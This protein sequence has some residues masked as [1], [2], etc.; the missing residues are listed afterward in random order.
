MQGVRK[1]A[2]LRSMAVLIV[3]TAVEYQITGDIPT[4]Q[5]MY[6]SASTVV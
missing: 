5:C 6:A 1:Y 3:A 2:W 4:A